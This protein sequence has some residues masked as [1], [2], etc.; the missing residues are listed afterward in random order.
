MNFSYLKSKAS[1]LLKNPYVN[2]LRGVPLPHFIGEN[3]QI[4]I[5]RKLE[6][7]KKCL[8]ARVGE[9][10][11]RAIAHYLKHRQVLSSGRWPYDVKLMSRLKLLAGYFPLTDES[12]DRLAKLYIRALSL[13][14]IY[15]IWTPHDVLLCP[16]GSTR[17][18]LVDLD[19]FFTARRWTLALEGLRVCVVSPF[20]ETMQQQYKKRSKCFPKPVLPDMDIAYVRAP[21]TQ[22]ETNVAGQDWFNNLSR[23]TDKVMETSSDVVIIGAGAYGLPLGASAKAYGMA[24]VVLGGA[25][26]LLFGIKGN[27]W[28][29][30]RQYQR[31][32]N[33][34]WVRL[35]MAERPPGFHNFEIKGGA[36][37]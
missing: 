23:L 8:I 3:A 32:F 20:I 37:W 24:A 29:N 26:Q 31:I 22:C 12:I 34:D 7:G 36:Y 13:I 35:S 18:R 16:P 5:A 2:A 33:K 30:D 4:A 14:D 19:P 21:M 28:E 27:R 25:T 9:N 15:A 6:E 10:E 17:I 1:V 11:G